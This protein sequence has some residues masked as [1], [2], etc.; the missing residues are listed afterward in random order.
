MAL[1]NLIIAGAPKCGTSSLF[2]WIAD[3]P[4]AEGSSIKETCYFADPSSHVFNANKNFGAGGLAGYEQFFPVTNPAAKIRLEAT[5]AYIYQDTALTHLP[6][7]PTEPKFLFILREPSRQILSTYRYFTN[8][9]NQLSADVS[10]A[11]FMAMAERPDPALAHNELLANALTNVQY[12][13]HLER[14]RDRTGPDRIFV[15]TRE[16]LAADRDA[17]MAA[18]TDWLGLD[19]RFYAEYAFP[20]ENETYRVKSH[21]LHAA[22]LRLRGLLA[23]TP[24]YVAARG[25]NRRLNTASDPAPL[26]PED[27]DALEALRL[28]YAEDNVALASAFGLDLSAWGVVPIT[29]EDA[30]AFP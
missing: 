5:P 16:A 15:M 10:F 17:A 24:L 11:E 30:R 22:N 7:L 4:E 26:S 13:T 27:T 12:A 25:A 28:R 8:N 9:W 6:D 2:Q 21:L 23:K 19:L 18:I 14:W 29:E 1:P 20:R 3:H